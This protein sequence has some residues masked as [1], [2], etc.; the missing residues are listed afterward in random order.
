MQLRSERRFRFDVPRAELWC[1]IADVDQYSRW[2]PWLRRFEGRGLVAGD[3]WHATVQPPLPYSLAFT[4]SLRH[5]DEGHLVEAH[6]DG[7]IRGTATLRLADLGPDG[8]G[9]SRG[10]GP[11][12]G[13]GPSGAEPSDGSGC[14]VCLTS[15]L[16]PRH[17]VLRAAALVASP[18]VRH[19]HDWVLDTGA[20][21]FVGRAL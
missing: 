15:A 13:A 20:R 17:P 2:W 10:V 16:A 18:I 4:V 14:E 7:D 6:V 5:V 8:S 21:Q 19:G 12:D 3:V 9:P 1:A 11:T